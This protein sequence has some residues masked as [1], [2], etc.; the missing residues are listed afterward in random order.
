[1]TLY[2]GFNPG[3]TMI[4]TYVNDSLLRFDE[5]VIS[6]HYE[7]FKL[8]FPN[9][10]KKLRFELE[11]RKSPEFYAFS[12]ESKSGVIVDNI[13]MRGSSGTL[14][15]KMNKKQ[16][17]AFLR[18][19]D[20]GLFILQY[21]GNTVPYIKSK[22]QAVKYGGWFKS[23][24]E[25]LHSLKPDAA[26]IV[27]GPSDMATKVGGK[28]M[29][30][31]YLIDVRDA[32]KK[33]AFETGAGFWDLYEVMGGKNAMISWVESDPPLA[34]ADYVH[35]N[36]RGTQRVA[37]LFIKALWRDFSELDARLKQ[38]IKEEKIEPDSLP[39]QEVK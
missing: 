35:F 3:E 29:T 25:Y 20:L 19:Q 10:P 22:E 39:E 23:Q 1:L 26:I 18:Q 17:A 34:G 32:L 30:F 4:N 11:G 15:K 24:I 8:S 9:S 12:M 7:Q 5:L 28:L 36:H 37:E 38:E 31:P 14:F 27:I 13:A 6:D 16:L 21:G 33:A 2:Y